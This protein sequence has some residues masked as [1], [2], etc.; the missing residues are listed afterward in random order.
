[1]GCLVPLLPTA[2]TDPP[3]LL[4]LG[5]WRVPGVAVLNVGFKAPLNPPPFPPNM[6]RAS[7]SAPPCP[8]SFLVDDSLY[9]LKANSD[10]FKVD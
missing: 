6:S 7:P 10:L 4:K 5:C 2:G 8:P 3:I 9:L 1:M